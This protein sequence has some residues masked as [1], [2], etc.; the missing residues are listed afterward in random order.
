MSVTSR[1][2]V[3]RASTHAAVSL[4]HFYEGAVGGVAPR[5]RSKFVGHGNPT[6]LLIRAFSGA[7]RPV[8]SCPCGSV[9]GATSCCTK[10]RKLLD[11]NVRE[12]KLP[13]E[14]AECGSHT[15]LER[16]RVRDGRRVWCG[17][18]LVI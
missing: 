18:G 1:D 3:G 8:L 6:A 15:V 12:K 16:D 4:T 7:Q 9:A 17:G 10:T 13:R 5:W 11:M 2:L 14:A